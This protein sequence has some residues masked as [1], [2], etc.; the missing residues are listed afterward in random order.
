MHGCQGACI[1]VVGLH[2]CQGECM[3]ARGVHGC[4]GVCMV[5]GHAWSNA[6]RGH[7]WLLGGMCGI[8]REMVN[9]RAVSI[10]LECILV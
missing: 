8:Q 7:V 1:V 4:G 6:C 9:E 10:L 5:G 3:V 2:S